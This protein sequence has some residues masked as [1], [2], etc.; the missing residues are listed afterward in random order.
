MN[1]SE[2]L[3]LAEHTSPAESG[4]MTPEQI[5]YNLAWHEIF[6]DRDVVLDNAIGPG[7]S[8]VL[9]LTNP[10]TIIGIDS[11]GLAAGSDRIMEYIDL[12]WDYITEKPIP[13]A[14]AFAYSWGTT[15]ENYIPDKDDTYHFWQDLGDRKRR[16]YWD[17][18]AINRWDIDRLLMIELKKLGVRRETIGVNQRPFAKY[19]PLTEIVF[20]WAFPGEN[21]KQ[22]RL[23]YLNGTV[24]SIVDG[25][26]VG[27]V[28]R[29]DCYHQKSLP[30][31][32]LTVGYLRKILPRL[33]GDTV[34]AVG[35]RFKHY[36]DNEEYKRDISQALG[37]DFRPLTSNE[38]A[39]AILD[40]LPEEDPYAGEN[41]YG[42]RLHIF[43]RSEADPQTIRLVV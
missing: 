20:D 21:L 23:L 43:R 28:S 42:M 6:G 2:I 22:R 14:G 7:I 4:L 1:R 8:N 13:R 29:I 32:D 27:F 31:D 17:M 34:V 39:E 9:H 19:V 26:E 38:T 37:K 11:K 10:S 15:P 35:Y 5:V 3:S 41:S 36:G 30:K 25:D 18:G 24:D 33:S 40:S 12:Y 16:G